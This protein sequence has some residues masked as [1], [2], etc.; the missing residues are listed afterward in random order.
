MFKKS[1]TTKQLDMFNSPSGLMC[2]RESHQYDDPSAW[3]N[4][5]FREVTSKIDEDI[6]RP[7]FKAER[8]DKKDGRPT[9]SIRI[10]IAMYILKE[11]CGCSDE[12]LYENCRFNL[13]YR[14][15]LGLFNLN[16]QCP[17]INSYYNIRRKMSEYEERTGINLFN[18]VFK[19]VTH[20]QIKEYEISGKTVRMDSKL[21]SSNIAWYSRY[22]IIQR[23]FVKE[24]T[25]DEINKIE[26]QMI[27]QKALAFFKEDAAK[28]I[29]K[30]ESSA[31]N[32]RLLDLGLVM[33]YVLTHCADGA[34]PLLKRVFDEQYE[35]SENGTVSVREKKQVS[36]K[37]LQNPNDTDAHY[38]SKGKQK[39]KGYTTNI[40]ETTDEA[41]KPSLITDVATKGAS[42]ADN[43]FLADAVKATEEVTGNKVEKVHADG[44]YQSDENRKLANNPDDGF[45]LVANGIQGKPSRFDLNLNDDNTLE[46]TDKQTGE[47]TNAIPVKPDK[48]KFKVETKKGTE[49][50]RYVDKEQVEKSKARRE[51]ESIPF[52]E[53][54][55]RNNVE[56]TM[57]QYSFHTRNNK[58]R[59]RGLFKNTVQAIGRCL[60]INVRRLFL[61]DQ[62]MA[63]QGA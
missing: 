22:E 2:D 61:F 43:K 37:S 28:I 8:E 63:L 44:A 34:K 5:F 18:S 32:G 9:T 41:G 4:K 36:A 48:W 39:V 62:R 21:I 14:S 1:S 24:M 38:R 42:A 53:R 25:E 26:D 54:K 11:G 29:Y 33:D 27:R 60:W 30:T 55:K 7:L 35:K 47:V 3:H 15:A 20:E 59:Y 13:L 49:A 6:F 51:V 40:T 19:Q 57:F 50:W 16:E 56:A 23:T 31:M 10:L 17:S 52:E 12:Q 46:V 58:T 45:D